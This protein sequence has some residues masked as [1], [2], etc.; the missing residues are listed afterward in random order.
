MA[1]CDCHLSLPSHW[2]QLLPYFHLTTLPLGNGFWRK[3]YKQ[4]LKTRR[5]LCIVT[6]LWS[7]RAGEKELFMTWFMSILWTNVKGKMLRRFLVTAYE[8]KNI[9]A[10]SKAFKFVLN[11]WKKKLLSQPQNRHFISPNYIYIYIYT[12]DSVLLSDE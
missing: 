5:V 1:K 7:D 10:V 9:I 3:P 6:G 2:N 12:H 4:N 11:N 8:D